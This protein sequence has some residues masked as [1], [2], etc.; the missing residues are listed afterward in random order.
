MQ[1]HSMPKLIACDL[2]GTLLNS[3]KEVTPATAAALERLMAKG[4]AFVPVTGRCLSAV[5]DQV[6][7]LAGLRYVITSNGAAADDWQSKHR[8]FTQ[9][10]PAPVVSH[11]F[12]EFFPLPVLTE[13]FLDGSAYVD[14]SAWE[15]LDSFGLS[16]TAYAY[17]RRTRKAIDHLPSFVAAHENA[18]ENINFVF[19]N[20]N[21][22]QQV[23]NQLSQNPN[24]T[25]TSS[26]AT[27]LEVTHPQ[28]TKGHALHRL[29]AQMDIQPEEVVSFGDSPN[30]S[31]LLSFTPHSY[32]MA[33][34][35]PSILAM[36]ANRAPSCEEEGVLQVLQQLFCKIL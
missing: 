13:V 9:S 11:L 2:D 32:A 3:K 28:A 34:G 12:Q 7:Q 17:V 5:P 22:R 26:S 1:A 21:L 19:T 31:D 10:L 15:N 8:L 35:T 20:E 30:D 29:C 24:L 23:K 36:A 25:V 14:Q 33:N 27:N 18:L 16:P 4:V 6:K